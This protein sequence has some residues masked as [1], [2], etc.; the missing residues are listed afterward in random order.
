RFE[1]TLPELKTRQKLLDELAAR[2]L[3]LP[4]V[5]DAT[6]GIIFRISH[7]RSIRAGTAMLPILLTLLVGGALV[8]GDWLVNDHT[9]RRLT[10]RHSLLVTFA[11]VVAGA[12]VHLTVE[13][14]KTS[15]VFGSPRIYV[16]GDALIWMHLRWAS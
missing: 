3:K 13:K 9:G 16:P 5:V 6:N 11:A 14:V 15:D 2:P 7:S 8:L 12:I 10:D 4:G 1:V